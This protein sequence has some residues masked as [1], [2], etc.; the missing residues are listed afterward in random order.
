MTTRRMPVARGRSARCEPGDV[1][2]GSVVVDMAASSGLRWA[3]GS[4]V[5]QARWR[6]HGAVGARCGWS[7][8]GPIELRGA[9]IVAREAHGDRRPGA[10]SGRDVEGAA[11]RGGA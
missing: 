6:R 5:A 2:R 7:A 4:T 8:R 11:G 10:G 3:D 1:G 9:P